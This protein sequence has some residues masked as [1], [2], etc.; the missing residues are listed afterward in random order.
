MARRMNRR[1]F[2]SVVATGVVGIALT[3]CGKQTEV[4]PP[5]ASDTPIPADTPTPRPTPEPTRPPAVRRLGSSARF[6]LPGEWAGFRG[7]G[8]LDGWQP[9]KGRMTRPDIAWKHFIGA[10]E[11]LVVGRIGADGRVDAPLAEVEAGAG[12]LA[13]FREA[14]W[15]LQPPLSEIAGEQRPVERSMTV[16][17]A[18]VLPDVPG[19][20]RIEFESSFDKPTVNG[21][22][23]PSVGRLQAWRNG[24]WE[25]V[26]ETETLQ[27]LFHPLPLVGDF[28]ADGQLEIVVLPWYDLLIFDAR[29]GKIKDQRRFNEGRAYGFFGAYDLDG[30]GRSEFVVQSDYS[31]HVNV[32][33]YVDGK[34]SSLWRKDIELGFGNPQKVL[35]VG[36][37]PVADVNGDRKL[38]VLVNLYNDAGDGRWHVTVHDGM[39]GAIRADL[40]DVHLDALADVNGDGI[41][42]LLVTRTAGQGLPPYGPV[43]VYSLASG[44]P[45]MLWEAKDAGWQV[46]EPPLPEHVNS[47]ATLARRTVLTRRTGA[48]TLAVLRRAGQT[49]G[50][51]QLDVVAWQDGSFVSRFRLAGPLLEGLALDEAG[52]LLARTITQPGQSAE[53]KGQGAVVTALASRQLGTPAGTAVVAA[54]SGRAPLVIAQSYAEELVAFTAPADGRPVDERRWQGRAQSTSWPGQALGPVLADLNGDGGR[55]CLYATIAPDGNAR[56]VVAELGGAPPA[57][58]RELWRHDFEAFPGSAPIWNLGGLLLWQ[59]GHFTNRVR[60]DVIVTL[61]RSIMHSDETYLLSGEDGHELWHRDHQLYDRG[62]G[63]QPYAI[64]DYDDDGLEEACS[65]YPDLFYIL[66]G[67]DGKE[68]LT[69]KQGPYWGQPIAGDWLSTGKPTVFFATER[70]SLTGVYRTNGSLAWLDAKDKSPSSLAAFGDFDGDGQLEA[71]GIG[72]PDGVR[73]YDTARGNVKWSL[74]TPVAGTPTGSASADVDG[75]GRDEA[76]FVIGPAL[77]CLGTTGSPPV[78]QV[79]WQVE[80]PVQVG[81][82]VPADAEGAGELSVLV[83]GTDGT[84]YCVR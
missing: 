80:F 65:L 43:A 48:T 71:I 73:C 69:P 3:A 2:L 8:T 62:V 79:R 31:K 59:V 17:Y 60:Q 67:S 45:E 20:E 11:T 55:Q 7:N 64:A 82:P 70:A 72:Y 78:G 25:T 77:Y 47:S 27:N 21:A 36:P 30:D 44:T 24:M 61:R 33:G 58:G 29:T 75:D 51:E 39:T 18:D 14:R 41:A 74:P 19:L 46:Y 34:L 28:D 38:E 42:E 22:W 66:E 83:V 23:A 68:T 4:V 76:L 81:P 6:P 52:E 9:M 40:Q 50:N 63:G 35:R 57:Q 56:L 12:D 10:V 32:L 37:N 13:E 84:V 5:T 26:W 54:R 16:T 15:G 1:K 49:L 53:I